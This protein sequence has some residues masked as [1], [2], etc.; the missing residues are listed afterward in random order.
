MGG[1]LSGLYSANHPED[2][3]STIMVCPYGSD[4]INWSPI[5]IEYEKNKT[6]PLICHKKED[7]LNMMTML[8][9]KNVHI[10]NIV[11]EGIQQIRA[12]GNWFYSKGLYMNQNASLISKSDIFLNSDILLV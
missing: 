10:P 7:F 8:C 3:L 5:R 11:A 6:N 9:Y 4:S 1:M 12:E 2:L